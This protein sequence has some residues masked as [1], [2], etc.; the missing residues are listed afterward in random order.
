[1]ELIPSQNFLIYIMLVESSK[2]K[3]ETNDI[4]EYY[5]TVNDSLLRTMQK[6]YSMLERFKEYYQK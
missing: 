6:D 4:V 5:W 1:M 2:F 3:K